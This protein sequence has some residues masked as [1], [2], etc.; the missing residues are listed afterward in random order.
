MGG[1]LESLELQWMVHFFVR[2]GVSRLQAHLTRAFPPLPA[3][4]CQRSNGGLKGGRVG[5]LIALRNVE[6]KRK[7]KWKHR[8]TKWIATLSNTKRKGLDNWSHVSPF[9][10]SFSSQQNAPSILEHRTYSAHELRRQRESS[11]GPAWRLGSMT[12]S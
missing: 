9:P 3:L 10:L 2:N 4:D 5:H 11:W 12:M 8:E 6:T 1:C 7:A